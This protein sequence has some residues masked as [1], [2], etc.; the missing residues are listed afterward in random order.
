VVVTNPDGYKASLAN[1]FTIHAAPQIRAITPDTGS[2][3]GIVQITDLAGE[4]FQPGATVRLAR[5]GQPD[6]Q[7]STVQVAN[8]R[9]IVCDFDLRG[10]TT[11]AW[12]VVVTNPDGR[13]GTLPAGY[14][15]L[16]APGPVVSDITP[17]Q[18]S[19]E[20]PVQ[21]TH[22]SGAH[23]RPGAQVKLVRAG[24]SDI[25]AS[26]VTVIDES[27]LACEFDIAGA[28]PGRW[29][30]VVTNPNGKSGAL[31]ESLAISLGPPPA[32]FSIA[33]SQASTGHMAAITDLIGAYFRPGVAVKLVKPGQPDILATSVSVVSG[34][35]LTCN[36]DLRGAA[37]GP[38][39]VVVT[40]AHGQ[41]GILA[42]GFLVSAP[43]KV[44]NGHAGRDWHTADNW[45]PGGVPGPG[46]TVT[47]PD[48]SHDPVI[49]VADVAIQD[50]SLEPG[51]VLD[52]TLRDLT[53]EGVLTNDG[54]LTQSRAVEGGQ[55]TRFL[56]ITNLAGD[57]TKY[58]GL[59][60]EA[61]D[62]TSAEALELTRDHM[63]AQAPPL[64][65]PNDQVASAQGKLALIPVADAYV[66]QGYPDRNY[67][68][69]AEM[70][71]GYDEYLDPDGR[72]ARSLL[73]FDLSQLAAGQPI[74]RAVLRA[75]LLVSWDFADA[76]RT[77]AVHRV[78]SPWS[79]DTVTWENMPSFGE[80]HGSQSLRHMAWA[81]YDFDLTE[82]VRDWYNGTRENHGI[83]LR[84]P[85]VAGQESSW[86]AFGS[87]ESP[88]QPHLVIE[89]SSDNTPPILA[90]LPDQ[91]LPVNGWIAE[92]IDLWEY[93]SDAQALDS[94]LRFSI[95][96]EPD[97][98]AGVAIVDGRYILIE[99]ERDW[100]GVT[101]VLIQVADAGGLTDE[102]AFRV[103][104]DGEGDPVVRVAISGNQYCPR[105]ASGV[106][107]CY[108]IES[109]TPLPVA[110]R[111]YFR[112]VEQN[113]HS[114]EDLRAY[115][116]ESEWNQVVSPYEQ[117][118]LHPDNGLYIEA[119]HA[120]TF[121]PFALDHS[122]ALGGAIYLP[123]A[124]QSYP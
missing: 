31:R 66:L 47:I 16:E 72:I 86:R 88:Y 83:M 92:A 61:G 27:Q 124:L 55:M 79:E 56:H 42:G 33:P 32:V 46:D 119:R 38:W 23:F 87:K 94:D 73:R 34:S 101:D 62:W 18:A 84:G 65:G 114:L 60:F 99:P 64:A 25:A 104:V 80:A 121:S 93:A 78:T 45:T 11:G 105:R 39:D 77:V 1:G 103:T 63:L 20:K 100:R 67:G 82:L 112:R 95:A 44:W 24:E 52:L 28:A 35:R 7:A 6:I 30:V 43:T 49:T 89:I 113:G 111:F 74:A 48:T 2:N 109:H 116:Y 110:L 10:A 85:E 37:A 12:D 108:H 90:P 40:T 71:T 69:S 118:A 68:A 115:H 57:E 81:W 29:D 70:W 17:S 15:V 102:Q 21:I 19:N 13:S 14:T 9:Q 50:L 117:G 76:T 97:L 8:P 59:D 51:A 107:R 120:G 106:R 36:L 41:T 5:P 96:N 22:L 58:Y 98:G 75:Y 54:T 26:N 53:V 4:N 91:T 122:G 123:L 3:D